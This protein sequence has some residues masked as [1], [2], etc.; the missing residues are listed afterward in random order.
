MPLSQNARDQV[1]AK[2]AEIQAANGGSL[3]GLKADDQYR[4]AYPDA[5]DLHEWRMEWNRVRHDERHPEDPPKEPKPP[6]APK[7]SK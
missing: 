5:V 4:I 7:P 6:K 1:R 2:L 3:D